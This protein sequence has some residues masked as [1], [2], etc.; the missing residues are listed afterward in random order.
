M[1]AQPN[2]KVLEIYPQH[3]ADHAGY[4]LAY[5]NQCAYYYMDSQTPDGQASVGVEY[6]DMYVD[7]THLELNLQKLL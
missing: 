6:Q 5:L 1:F 4:D 2:T 3:Y 7:I